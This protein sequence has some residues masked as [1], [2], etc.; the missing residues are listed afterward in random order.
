M[1]DSQR[2]FELLRA[3]DADGLRRLLEQDSA[4][5]DARDTTGVS[6]LMHSLYRGQRDV[7]ELIASKKTRSTSLKPPRSVVSIA[8]SSVSMKQARATLPPSTPVPKT[9]SAPS[10]SPAFLASPQPHACCS[11]AE[12]PLTPWPRTRPRSCRC[13]PPPPFATSKPRVSFLS[14]EHRSMPASKTAGFQF[15]PPLRMETA[16]WSS[17]CSSTTPILNSPTTTARLQPWL[18]EKKATRKSPRC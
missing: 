5:S 1:T 13:T 14:A 8:S 18:P 4:A 9:D 16:P 3:N 6:L 17:S 11:K 7:A 12:P 10:T 15:T 2:A